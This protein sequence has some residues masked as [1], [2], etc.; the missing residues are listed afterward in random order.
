M[1]HAFAARTAATMHVLG[2]ALR[3]RTATAPRGVTF[4]EYALLAAVA[5]VIGVIFKTQLSG[6]FNDILGRIKNGVA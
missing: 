5:V 2:G 1:F 3:A 4:I 6:A